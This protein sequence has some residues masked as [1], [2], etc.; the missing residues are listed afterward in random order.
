M[1]VMKKLIILIIGIALYTFLLNVF[2]SLYLAD[3]YNSQSKTYLGK[4]EFVKAKKYSDMT[5]RE[6]PREPSYYRYKAKVMLAE[7]GLG[8]Q[9]ASAIKKEINSQLTKSQ[10]LNNKNLTTLRNIIPLY[11]FLALTDITADRGPENIDEVYLKVARDYYQYLKDTYPNDLGIIT[12]VAEYERKL[13][14]N[15]EYSDSV[16]M[17]KNLRPEIINWHKAFN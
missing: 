16:E 1:L 7:L 11:Y 15:E 10:E 5:T 8:V 4:G 6:N 17:V 9:D 12:D 13:Y 3:V 2:C 14:L